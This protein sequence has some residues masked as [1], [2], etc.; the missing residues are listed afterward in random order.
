M[1]LLLS[2][3]MSSAQAAPRYERTIGNELS[4]EVGRITGADEA[5]EALNDYDTAFAT[6]GLRGAYALGEHLSLMGSVHHGSVGSSTYIG[7]ERSWETSDTGGVALYL[8]Q[9]AVGPKLHM[10]PAKRLSVYG[11][12]QAEALYGIL[13]L[14]SNI[15]EADSAVELRLR[16][17][18]PGGI[19]AGG[20]ELLPFHAGPA[21]LG[22]HLELG[23]AHAARMRF[24]DPEGVDA[25][26]EGLL[27]GDLEAHGLHV[28]FG[29]GARF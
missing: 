8:T 26:D 23:Y 17:L 25:E 9:L 27:V 3:L 18:A 16:G 15:E 20:V 11:T 21:S 22:A 14:D 24:R 10:E 2:V 6:R 1:F 7:G 19:V 4:L 29:V 13:K 5:F 28:R 12:L